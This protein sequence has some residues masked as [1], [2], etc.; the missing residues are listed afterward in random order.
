MKRLLSILLLLLAPVLCG[1]NETEKSISWQNTGY[2][3][4]E[5]SVHAYF[6]FHADG[7]EPGSELVF[8]TRS[9]DGQL[10]QPVPVV[11]S[12]D[13]WINSPT[14]RFTFSVTSSLGEVVSAFFCEPD[15]TE[16]KLFLIP[17][18]L[19]RTGK[20][21]HAVHL[22]F[23]DDKANVWVATSSGYPANDFPIFVGTATSGG[24]KVPL[25]TVSRLGHFA[26]VI[27]P[28]LGT[29]PDGHCTVKVRPFD[30]RRVFRFKFGWGLQNLEKPSKKWVL[31]NHKRGLIAAGMVPYGTPLTRNKEDLS[32]ETALTKHLFKTATSILQRHLASIENPAGYDVMRWATKDQG[33]GLGLKVHVPGTYRP[34][35]PLDSNPIEFVP[36]GEK[37]PYSWSEL[38]AVSSC[39]DSPLSSNQ[40]AMEALE[41][42]V[43]HCDG[44]ILSRR[45]YQD[46]DIEAAYWAAVYTHQG[47][48]KVL[49]M[50]FFATGEG[51]FG[52]HYGT[53]VDPN[54]S[55][56]SQAE[57]AFA[58]LD[59]LY[60][61][62]RPGDSKGS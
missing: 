58:K 7:F 3:E 44:E 25:D 53:I 56:D 40:L 37:D 29:R 39:P 38:I 4:H 20:K 33:K 50:T 62:T 14:D 12:E 49:A 26:L 13:G 28:Q 52:L 18:P 47:Q 60:T 42:L 21:G 10:S 2:A 6:D 51:A 45:K 54:E 32:A 19:I 23:M 31:D 8:C 5:G 15:G 43:Q 22:A 46:E 36:K 59:S 41:V 34:L 9:Y 61:I 55:L 48:R 35:Q 1:A 27:A 11:V 30:S 17:F 24:R 57:K 16:H